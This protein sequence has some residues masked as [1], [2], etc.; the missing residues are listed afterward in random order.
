[1]TTHLLSELN[2][3]ENS[4]CTGFVEVRQNSRIKQ[5]LV[6]ELEGYMDVNLGKDI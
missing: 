4:G 6:D 1:M 3:L 5:M 2:H